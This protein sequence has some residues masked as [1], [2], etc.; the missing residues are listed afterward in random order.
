[1]KTNYMN[2][3][4]T[5]ILNKLVYLTL[6]FAAVLFPASLYGN[7]VNDS[8][9]L[10][11]LKQQ[12]AQ[13][14]MFRAEMSHFFT[15]SFSGETTEVYGT[16]WFARDRYRIETPDQVVVVSGAT[17]TVLN[18]R[19]NRVIISYYDAD[20]DEFAPSRFF[21]SD[22]E[23]FN[24]TDQLN[25]DGSTTIMITSDDPF[26]LFQQVE[27]RLTRE[28]NPMQIDA[29]DQMDNSVRTMFRFGRFS[30]IDASRF[31]LLPP[32]GAEIV[33]LRE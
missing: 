16:I 7:V 5:S 23:A 3:C 25:S 21:A 27:I 30:A 8:P 24:S 28:G 4:A 19:Q 1:M 2:I 10:E 20:E 15:D 11:R 14:V 17:S 6:L 26:E 31:E 9:A 13:D 29:I 18:I 22:N 32:Q 12:F 33:D